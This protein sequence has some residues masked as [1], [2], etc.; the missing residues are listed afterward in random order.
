MVRLRVFMD[1]FVSI[2]IAE[3]SQTELKFVLEN[4]PYHLF[5]SA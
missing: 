5:H 4:N 1:A 3:S 2:R